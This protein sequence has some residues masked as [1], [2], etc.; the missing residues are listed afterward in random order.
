MKKLKKK[1]FFYLLTVSTNLTFKLS[2]TSQFKLKE[3]NPRSTVKDLNFWSIFRLILSGEY[4]IHNKFLKK[5]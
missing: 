5:S 4:K 1:F 3:L 2:L